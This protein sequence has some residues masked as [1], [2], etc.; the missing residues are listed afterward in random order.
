VRPVPTAVGFS[1]ERDGDVWAV[2]WGGSVFRIQ[3]SRGMQILAHLVSHPGREFHVTDLSAP[4]GAPGHLEDAG[5]MLDPEA[6]ASYRRRLEEV[7]EELDEAER[8]NDEGRQARLREE[9][10]FLAAELGRAV[11][12]GGRRRK[13]ASSSEK[14]RVNVKRRLS[15]AIGKI[16]EHSPGLGAHLDWAV[17]TGVFCSYRPAAE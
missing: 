13:A 12:L 7:R 6:I 16:A 5:E 8:W 1:L 10:E 11:G 14:A 17:K 3:D 9:M 2:S 4:G 15:H